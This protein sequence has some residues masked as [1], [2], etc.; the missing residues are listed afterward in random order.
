MSSGL[1]ASLFF[2]REDVPEALLDEE[3]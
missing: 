1:L 3:P 2:D